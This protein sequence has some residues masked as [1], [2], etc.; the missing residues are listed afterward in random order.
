MC[1]YLACA[2]CC[3]MRVRCAQVSSSSR[4]RTSLSPTAIFSA[5]RQSS[6]R[7]VDR[8]ARCA[9]Y[10]PCAFW[11]HPY[12][13]SVRAHMLRVWRDSPRMMCLCACVPVCLCACVHVCVTYACVCC[14]ARIDCC[15]AQTKVSSTERFGVIARNKI[16][17]ANAAHWFDNAHEIIFEHNIIRP[18]GTAPSWG[19]NI[20]N[21]ASSLVLARSHLPTRSRAINV[22]SGMIASHPSTT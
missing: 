11:T 14:V 13:T 6:T 18:A 4:V 12:C 9:W 19:N 5:R 15:I 17:N 3:F 21:C 2:V 20:D 7:V 16:W 22:P 8:S 1:A 10:H